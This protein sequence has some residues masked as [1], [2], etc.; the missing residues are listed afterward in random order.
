V[1]E[2]RIGDDPDRRLALLLVIS[3]VPAAVLG[4]I[5]ES[6]FDRTFREPD[7]LILV[8]VLLAAGALLLWLAERYGSRTRGLTAMDRGDAVVIGVAQALALFPGISR[9]GVTIAAGLFRGLQRETAARFAF[10]MGIPVIAGAGLWK[11]RELVAA[12]PASSDLVALL[13]G[14]AAA[15]IAGLLAISF[16]LRYLRTN[17]TGIF[18]GYRLIAAAVWA[19]L[20]IIR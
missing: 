13:A 17:T 14:M 8:P 12:P 11:A 4:A 18:I 6:F 20:L 2:R 3:V 16:L 5:G 7:H 10:L 15:A 19:V 9:S 1:R